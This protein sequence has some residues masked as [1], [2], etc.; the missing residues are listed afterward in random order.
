MRSFAVD[1]CARCA[2]IGAT[3]AHTHWSHARPR[4]AKVKRGLESNQAERIHKPNELNSLLLFSGNATMAT[5]IKKQLLH[6]IDKCQYEL[7]K[8]YFSAPCNARTHTDTHHTTQA[9]SKHTADRQTDKC[10]CTHNQYTQ[11]ILIVME[12]DAIA[13]KCGWIGEEQKQ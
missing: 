7:L 4:R 8:L 13:V 6:T 11:I 3:H 2:G 5:P 1:L 10:T 9:H 12:T